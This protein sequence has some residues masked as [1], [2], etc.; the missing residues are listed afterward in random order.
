MSEGGLPNNIKFHLH[1]WLEKVDRGQGLNARWPSLS[2]P[3]IK[4][5]RVPSCTKTKKQID[6]DDLHLPHRDY[7]IFG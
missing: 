2:T 3:L 6:N 4:T 5:R 7:A 1:Q